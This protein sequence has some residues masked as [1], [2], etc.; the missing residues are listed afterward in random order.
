MNKY[1]RKAIVEVSRQRK[2]MKLR[3]SELGLSL[4]KL[5][6]KSG[7][8]APT[9]NRFENGK[10]IELTNFCSLFAVLNNR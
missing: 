5:A 10:E 4:R 6:S 7:V 3:R 1:K 2:L 8:S 9:I